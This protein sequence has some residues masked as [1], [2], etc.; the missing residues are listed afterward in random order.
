M[1]NTVKQGIILCSLL[2]IIVPAY[3]QDNDGP[4]ILYS[5]EEM[6]PVD[7]H[8]FS[9]NGTGYRDEFQIRVSS[10]KIDESTHSIT[11]WIG[12]TELGHV[13]I[14]EARI[15]NIDLST[16][17]IYTRRDRG[18]NMIKINIKF[19]EENSCFINDDGRNVGDRVTVSGDTDQ[20]SQHPVE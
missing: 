9:I 6:D 10:V 18:I 4:R 1:P 16:A 8:E 11:A 7:V 13:I 5:V 12:H 15:P 19:G 3:A 17:R 14:R 20:T 2:G